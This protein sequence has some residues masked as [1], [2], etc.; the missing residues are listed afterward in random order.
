[1][2]AERQVS[3]SG[4]CPILQV[5]VTGCN[6]WA[7]CRPVARSRA[8]EVRSWSQAVLRPKLSSS[9]LGEKREREPAPCPS[10]LGPSP[11]GPPGPPGPQS[12]KKVLSGSLPTPAPARIA[13]IGAGPVGLWVA[14]LLARAHARFFYTSSG[15]RITRQPQAPL[16]NVSWHTLG[17]SVFL[18]LFS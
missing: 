1:M 14:V 10:D 6:V 13:I 18:L 16:I 17:I 2:H 12:P 4:S 5:T 8:R 15:Y 11:P 7:R 9:D 3:R